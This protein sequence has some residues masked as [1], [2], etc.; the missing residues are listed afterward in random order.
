MWANFIGTRVNFADIAAAAV[1][2][3]AAITGKKLFSNSVTLL[4]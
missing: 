4:N 2:A 3:V 1:T